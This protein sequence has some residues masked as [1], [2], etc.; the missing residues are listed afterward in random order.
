[1]VS[2]VNRLVHGF[3]IQKFRREKTAEHRS[4]EM[5][6]NRKERAEA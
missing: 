3:L 6:K 4:V 5:L 1:M 2:G